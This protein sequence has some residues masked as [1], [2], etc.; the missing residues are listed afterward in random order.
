MHSAVTDVYQP[1]KR[2]AFQVGTAFT[3]SRPHP[4]QR[5]SNQNFHSANHS[6]LQSQHRPHIHGTHG[7]EKILL[8]EQN[9]KLKQPTSPPYTST[10]TTAV[11][12]TR[13]ILPL[14]IWSPKPSSTAS[15]RAIPSPPP[16]PR[17][18][19]SSP[20]SACCS[21]AGRSLD[22]CST[23]QAHQA[24]QGQALTSQPVS[25]ARRTRQ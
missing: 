11:R 10:T 25:S 22:H 18:P 21:S 9:K 3:P 4:S 5:T 7:T 19:A 12:P 15:T 8:P 16:P 13:M 6:R 23:H 20:D 2:R 1:S 17:R 24:R 14:Q